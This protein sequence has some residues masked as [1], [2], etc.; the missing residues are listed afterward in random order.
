[1]STEPSIWT[2]DTV[3][4]IYLALS[5]AQGS[6]EDIVKDKKVIVRGV[7][8]SGKPFE[9]SYMYAP[10]TN[11]LRATKKGLSENELGYTQAVSP[12]GVHVATRL[13][14]SSGQW[15]QSHIP[16][17]YGEKDMQKNAGAITFFKRYGLCNLLGVAGEDDD[18]GNGAMGHQADYDQRPPKQKNDRYEPA[19][20]PAYKMPAEPKPVKLKEPAKEKQFAAGT[21][22]TDA[23]KKNLSIKSSIGTPPEGMSTK[24]YESI[25]A[26]GPPRDPLSQITKEESGMLRDQAKNNGWD[27]ME[28]TKYIAETY[29]VPNTFA[30]TH[31]Q[32]QDFYNKLLDQAIEISEKKNKG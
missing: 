14:H 10:I 26:S 23:L 25:L 7:T 28:Y 1:M 27:I 19:P 15:I 22:A 31:A 3:D 20:M 13:F 8:K 11:I 30:M 24:E 17:T 9:Y 21:T 16:I 12:D 18:D 29:K 32:F 6:F 5:K 2:S 4:K